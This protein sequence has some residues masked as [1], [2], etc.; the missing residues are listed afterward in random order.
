MNEKPTILVVDDD[1]TVQAVFSTALKSRY[2][3]HAI[4]NGDAALDFLSRQTADAIL[5]DVS[6]PGIDGYETCRRIKA[7]EVTANIPVIFVSAQDSVE[8][9]LKGFDAGG[10]DYIVKPFEMPELLARL[11]HLIQLFDERTGLKQLVESAS[12]TA[13]T[14]MS[15]LS[16]LG[17]LVDITK[18]LGNCENLVELADTIVAGLQQYGLNSSTQIREQGQPITRSLHG[19]AT[20]LESSVIEHMAAEGDRIV[21]FR[22]RLSIHYE[23]VS[24][25]VYDLPLDDVERCGRL[26]DHLAMLVEAA[27]SRYLAIHHSLV[28][29][30]TIGNMTAMLEEIDQ[31]Q[32]GERISRRLAI[33]RMTQHLSQ[34]YTSVALST[35]QEDFMNTVID[36]GVDQLISTYEDKIG[37]Q[38][39]L[40]LIVNELKAIARNS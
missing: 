20:P 31:S 3:V 39:K 2:V 18:R 5:L 14:A 19:K 24:I 30:Q 1:S 25:L 29:R 32:R 33:E 35:E 15:S 12:C 11:S 8:D 27:E 10:E 26:R 37:I 36:Q 21:Q 4:G 13:L 34:A 7:N 16:E 28:I 9:R 6:M 40:T 23:H 38:D 17:V 22:S